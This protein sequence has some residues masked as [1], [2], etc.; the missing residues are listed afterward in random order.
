MGCVGGDSAA[1]GAHR[2]LRR[3]PPCQRRLLQAGPLVLSPL[4]FSVLFRGYALSPVLSEGPLHCFQARELSGAAQVPC[5]SCSVFALCDVES[6]ESGGRGGWQV[7]LHLLSGHALDK[8]RV[9][10]EERPD[11]AAAAL[12]AGLQCLR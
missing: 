5:S 7:G 11:D 4:L 9:F 3:H 10:E 1:D 8:S 12:Q 2:L 6:V